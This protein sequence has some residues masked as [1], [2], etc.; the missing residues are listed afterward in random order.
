MEFSERQL[1]L[2]ALDID[3][4]QWYRRSSGAA[5]MEVYRRRQGPRKPLF[6][7]IR[8]TRVWPLSLGAAVL[9]PVLIALTCSLWP[10]IVVLL[11]L[12]FVTVRS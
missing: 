3:N 7:P 12:Y 8:W 2:A 4:P 1:N 9:L 10:F 6:K 5:R 11:T